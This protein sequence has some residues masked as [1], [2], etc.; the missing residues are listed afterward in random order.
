L[1][2][3]PDFVDGIIYRSRLDENRFCVA[4]YSDRI[5]GILFHQAKE[6]LSSEHFNPIL[7]EIIDTYGIG[8]I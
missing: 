1:W 8:L 5:D 6:E 3:H 7:M 2:Q 4:L